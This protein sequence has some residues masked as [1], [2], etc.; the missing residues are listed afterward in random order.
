MVLESF[1]CRGKKNLDSTLD[2]DILSGE[3]IVSLSMILYLL[4]SLV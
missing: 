1:D 2:V 3:L 4:F